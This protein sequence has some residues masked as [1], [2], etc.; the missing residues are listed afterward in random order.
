M[1][2]LD[3]VGKYLGNTNTLYVAIAVVVLALGWAI[4]QGPSG[5]QSVKSGV[6]TLP[7]LSV[8][9]LCV[10]ILYIY[11]LPAAMVLVLGLCIL[12]ALPSR[13]MAVESFAMRE[14]TDEDEDED[15]IDVLAKQKEALNS[16]V[17]GNN[18][19][20]GNPAQGSL[21]KKSRNSSAAGELY[22]GPKAGKASSDADA[23]E[24]DK[25]PM[26]AGRRLQE[27]TPDEPVRSY[28]GKSM[29]LYNN[30][31]ADMFDSAVQNNRKAMRQKM[32]T[33]RQ[34][35]TRSSKENYED[36]NASNQNAGINI[37]R[38]RFNL[39]DEIDKDLINTREICVD[40]INR[41]NYEYED[42]EYLKKYIAARVEEIIDMNKLL[43]DA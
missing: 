11:N 42:K 26:V 27:R 29:G 38:R 7:A 30:K 19:K 24:L 22:N 8:I 17:S 35:N 4:S 39:N 12:L 40:I 16:A 43:D 28:L 21:T 3:T 32:K 20:L 18:T 2:N 6:M 14:D 10:F 37:E 31:Y 41:I 33:I 1:M 5:R 25:P 23:D 15:D 9:L 36:T 13:S 34:N